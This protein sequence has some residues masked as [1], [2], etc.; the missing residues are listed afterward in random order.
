M[1]HAGDVLKLKAGN[2]KLQDSSG[3]LLQLGLQEE[4]LPVT[5]EHRELFVVQFNSKITRSDRTQLESHHTVIHRYL[6]DDAYLVSATKK[7]IAL[8]KLAMPSIQAVAAFDFSWK[9]SPELNRDYNAQSGMV[10]STQTE[11]LTLMIAD[12]DWVEATMDELRAM[13]NLKVLSIANRDIQ[14]QAQASLI[15]TI[16]HMAS[17]EWIQKSP[18]IVQYTMP[19]PDPTPSVSPS[20]SAPYVY[21]GYESGTKVMKFD[22]AYARG[23]HG[24]GQIV[25]IA[26]SGADSGDL[27]TLHPDLRTN[28]VAGYAIGLGGSSWADPMGHGTHTAG[29]FVGDG[30]MSDG[31]IRGGAYGAH[32]IEL[33]MWS[34]ILNNLAPGTDFNVIVGTGY[35][36]GARVHSNSWGGAGNFGD[37][38]SMASNVDDYLFHHQ[39]ILVLFAA[40]NSGQD[41]DKNGVIDENS[42]GS[43]GTAKNVLTVGASKN[44]LLVGGIQ[45][46]LGQLRDGATKWGVPPLRDDTLSNNPNGLACFSSR[47]PTSD[48][49]IKP[50]IVAPGTNIISTRDHQAGAELLWGIFDDNYLY[51]GGTSMAT[52]LTA[53]AA[54]VGR[55]F[56][57]EQRQIAD[58]SGAL[59]KALLMHTA[60]DMYPGQY[61]TGPTQELPTRRPNV[62]EGYGRVDMDVA[63]SLGA[64]TTLVDNT[65]GVATG[66]NA[67]FNFNV[68]S[69]KALRATLTYTDASAAAEAAKTL[70][71]DLD[72]TITSP[73]GK[74]YTLNDHTNNTEMLEIP[75]GE[76]GNYVIT[77]MGTNVPQGL[78]GKQPYALIVGEY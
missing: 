18:I 46:T 47:G 36:K 25:A 27:S 2:I 33:G 45:K 24:E 70:V 72:L 29:S 68:D 77:V 10:S 40:G 20:P 4:N 26:D 62:H 61:G 69:G 73:S 28:L 35:D 65:V 49:R 14:I 23:Y 8:A 71:N 43:P 15:P 13:P 42:I 32:L 39:D 60:F 44:Y 67:T 38:D 5:R 55:Q 53:A 56:L 54:A 66:E 50:E 37:Y 3:S 34:D 22:A 31:K 58:P 30:T 16:A 48:G 11:L 74:V 6:P 17:V 9:I 52:P 76:A 75:A 57:V 12:S 19:N 21:T 78:S 1:A 41:L 51:S 64:E 59:V 63:T 7:N